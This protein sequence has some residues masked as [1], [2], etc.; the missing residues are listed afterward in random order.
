MTRLP[1]IAL[2]DSSGRM[3]GDN[4]TRS[5]KLINDL[6]MSIRLNPY[7]LETAYFSIATFNRIFTPMLDFLP[8]SEPFDLPLLQ[9]YPSSPP[10]LGAAL[11]SLVNWLEKRLK[12]TSDIKSVILFFWGGG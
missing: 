9:A 7:A 5:N 6:V 1:I 4:I 2:V 11:T 3:Y 8:F 10:M 12:A